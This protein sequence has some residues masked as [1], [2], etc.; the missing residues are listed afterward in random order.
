MMWRLSRMFAQAP[1]TFPAKA[2]HGHT[3]ERNAQ[4]LPQHATT[5]NALNAQQTQ[6]WERAPQLQ[7]AEAAAT[8]TALPAT[9]GATTT[10][11]AAQPAL[12]PRPTVQVPEHA[13]NAIQHTTAR[14]FALAE[15][16]PQSTALSLAIAEAAREVAPPPNA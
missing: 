1:K 12:A 2:A 16:S 3:P 15:A 14:R 4:P 7:T 13:S 9:H 5:A 10:A 11:P 6:P 8:G